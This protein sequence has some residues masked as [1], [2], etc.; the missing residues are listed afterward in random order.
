MEIVYVL[1]VGWQFDTGECGNRVGAYD[2]IE[3]AQAQM[4]KEIKCAKTDFSDMDTEEDDYVDGDMSWSIW[5]KGEY[6]YNHCDIE[7]REVEVQ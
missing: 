7:I 4:E 2:T 5:E 1:T 6:C 3:K